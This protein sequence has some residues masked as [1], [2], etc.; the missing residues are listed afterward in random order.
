MNNFS[1]KFS[2]YYRLTWREY[3]VLF[4]VLFVSFYFGM[5]SYGIEN[6]NEGLY[7]E[8]PREMLQL[9]NYIIPKLNFVPYIEKPPLFYWLIALSYKVFG[10]SVWSARIVPATSGALVCL[11]FVYF[12]NAIRRNR[13]GWLSAIILATSIGFIAIARVLIFDM[14]LTFFFTGA[15]LSFYVWYKNLNFTYLRLFYIFTGFAF[16]TKGMLALALIPTIT[17]LFLVSLPNPWKRVAMLFDPVGLILF[18]CIVVPWHY[19]AIKQQSGFAWDYFINEQFYRFLDKRVPHDYHTGPF[20]FYLPKIILSL[21]PWSLLTF[22]LFQPKKN[23]ER[24]LIKFLWLWFIIPLLFFSLSKAKGDYYMVVGIPPLAF[25]LGLKLNDLFNGKVKYTLI[26]LFA[27]LGL[28][29]MTIFGGLYLAT[30]KPLWAPTLPDLCKLD[31]SFSLPLL[32]LFIGVSVMTFIGGVIA[33]RCR[34]NPSVQLTLIA[35]LMSFTVI[36]YIVD[37]Q[38]VQDSRSESSLAEYIN[39][40]AAN[41]PVYLYQDYEKISSIL[42]YLKKRLPLID[43]KSQDLYYGSRSPI[44]KGWFYS[45]NNF[46]EARD[47][48]PHYVIARKDRFT[49]FLH[50]VAPREYCIV[51]QSGTSVLLS[52]DSKECA[53]GQ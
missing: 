18:A 16:L 5:S 32:R 51:A 35:C 49:E 42:F 19:F 52:N 8:I 28:L 50:N 47:K 41:R 36:F 45:L 29:E 26:N 10:V 53:G 25:L 31:P 4:L 12:G 20:Y 6:I 2:T 11:S 40:H 7:A 39:Q 37:K 38:I 13:E 44:A 48:E 46:L 21:F 30:A 27:V 1:L 23:V 3:L 43:S 15:L 17:L 24:P 33:W 14:L 34:R 9:G 22:L